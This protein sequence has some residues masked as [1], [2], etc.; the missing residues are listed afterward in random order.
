ME[1]AVD[2]LD[3]TGKM[4]AEAERDHTEMDRIYRALQSLPHNSGMRL[5]FVFAFCSIF[6]LLRI[7]SSIMR[8]GWVST[9]STFVYPPL[10]K[11]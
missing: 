4:L 7:H 11:K 3:R 6:N 8:V 10:N 2:M 9:L 5:E 1:C